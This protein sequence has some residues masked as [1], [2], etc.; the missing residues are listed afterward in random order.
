[1]LSVY[2][3]DSAFTSN[4]EQQYIVRMCLRDPRVHYGEYGSSDAIYTKHRVYFFMLGW[5]VL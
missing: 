3:F 2:I 1:M 4:E 5:T